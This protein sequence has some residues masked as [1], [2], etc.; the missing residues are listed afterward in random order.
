MNW[1][2]IT[3][4]VIL[5]L[6]AAL[7]GLYALIQ[8]RSK[9]KADVAKAITEAAGELIG[10]YKDKIDDIEAEVAEQAEL[11]KCQERKIDMQDSRITQ[12]DIRIREQDEKIKVMEL[13]KDEILEGVMSLCTQIQDLGHDP[14]W[15]PDLPE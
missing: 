15:E 3:P 8:S 6:I 4:Q 9:N 10:E 13:D 12:Q 2:D 7:S 1:Q 5:T 11:I 14:V